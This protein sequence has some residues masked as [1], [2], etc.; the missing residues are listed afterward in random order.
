M[1]E[2]TK[3]SLK[4]FLSVICF[5]VIVYFAI[6]FI[7]STGMVLLLLAAIGLSLFGAYTLWEKYAKEELIK[8]EE[9]LDILEKE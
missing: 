6:L 8:K 4:K 1:E 2:S 3:K 5:G 9:N 7:I